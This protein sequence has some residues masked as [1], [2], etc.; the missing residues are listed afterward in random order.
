[1]ENDDTKRWEG[2]GGFGTKVQLGVIGIAI[3]LNIIFKELLKMGRGLRIKKLGLGTEPWGT[4][5]EMGNG[6]D[7]NIF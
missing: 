2:G 3:K 4:L 6:W 7:V 5:E 1:M